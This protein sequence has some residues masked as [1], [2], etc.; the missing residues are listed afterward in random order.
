M[1]GF[2]SRGWRMRLRAAAASLVCVCL[3]LC[4]A[5]V[6]RSSGLRI[7][8]RAKKDARVNLNRTRFYREADMPTFG[9]CNN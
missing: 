7:D 8:G 6:G 3:S 2:T 5:R 4:R 9:T 1:H